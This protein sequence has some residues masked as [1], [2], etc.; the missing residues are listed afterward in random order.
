MRRRILTVVRRRR[1]CRRCHRRLQIDACLER[2]V[3]LGRESD[4]ANWLAA[5]ESLNSTLMLRTFFVGHRLSLADCALWHALDSS[6][7][8]R[9]VLKKNAKTL[10]NVAVHITCAVCVCMCAC[11]QSVSFVCF[12]SQR[13]FSHVGSQAAFASDSSRFV[14]PAAKKKVAVT[15]KAGAMGSHDKIDVAGT[16]CTRF[17]PEPS[18]YLHIGHM[19]AALLNDHYA[20]RAGG[21]LLL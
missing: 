7:I 16:V 17:P 14:V 19:K 4:A 13:W 12:A 8:A 3:E 21:R 5:L 6:D 15:G 2:A 20:R 9:D 11:S 18:G 1:R 10:P